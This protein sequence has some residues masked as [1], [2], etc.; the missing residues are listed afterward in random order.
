ML[1]QRRMDKERGL[2]TA[3]FVSG[4]RGS[5]LGGVDMAMWKAQKA[6]DANQISFLPG[7]NEDLAAT[8]VMGTQQAGM[9]AD[10]KVDGVFAMW[11]GK[12]PGVDR[13]G[14]ALHHGNAAGASRNGGVLVVVGDDH[15]AVSSSIPHASEASLIGWQMPIVHPSSIDE[16]ETFALWGWALSRHSGAWVAFKAVSE[17]IECGHSFTPA[18]PQHYDMP[19]DPDLPPEMLEY[20]ARD[21]LSLA[22]ETRMNLRMK[23]VAAFARRHSI[24]KLAC[25]APKAVAGI[26]TVGKA[27]LDTMEALARLGVDTF[28]ANAPVRIYKP[29]L[30][31]PLDAGR[32]LE[33]A[34][35]LSHILVIEEKGAVVESQI[36]DLLFNLPDRPTVIGKKGFDGEALVPSAG[37]LRPSLLARPLAAW[38]TRAAGLPAAGDLATFDCQ[39]PCQRGRR[40][41]PPP[42]LLF[43]LSPQHLDQG[44]RGQPGP[45]GRGLPLHGCLDGPRHGRPDPDGRRRRGLD[46]SVPLHQDAARVPEHGRRHLLPLRL[47]GHPPGGRGA[48][49][50]H[51]QDPVQRRRGH[52]RRTAG[53]RPDLGAADLPATARRERGPHRRHLRRTRNTRAWTWAASACTTAASWTRC[54]VNCARFPES[55]C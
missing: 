41:A 34:R 14:D 38:L 2:N 52:D 26:V 13:A 35:G 25:P 10:R 9:R 43:G 36:K 1:T 50:H 12:G 37:Q 31:W 22:V 48:R 47:P 27:H 6:L 16:Y 29:G 17:T 4:Y 30:T 15:T 44:A 42:L 7:I 3:G 32:L 46:R 5:P 21:F 24:D 28:T 8:A 40:H 49:Q 18:P 33:F 51:L 23:A 45:V 55:P 19:A 54:S 20:S 11:Y 39:A 53:G